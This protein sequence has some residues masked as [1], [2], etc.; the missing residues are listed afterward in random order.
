MK[1]IKI[2]SFAL[3][4]LVTITSC[5]SSKITSAWKAQD[6]TP[7]H[8][9]KILVLGLIREKDRSIQEY[10]ENH[11]VGDLKDLGYD[12]VSSLQ[13]YGP[14]AFDKMEEPEVINSLKSS[15]I[16]AVITIVLLDKK[17]EQKYIPGNIYYTP[18][19]YYSNRFWH[20]R[21]TLY[22][23]IYEPG[24]YMINTKYFWESNLYDMSTQKLIYSVQTQSFD[25]SNL[26]TMGHEYG[27]MIINNMIK[28]D[29]LIM[30]NKEAPP[31]YKD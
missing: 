17:R 8:F 23:R 21:F 20:Y 30:P 9:N 28:N 12:A 5:S 27:K 25:P 18:Y 7:R 4:I 13:V 31:A 10:M 22:N 26:E 19:G 14:K 11:M 6:I 29:V 3:A 2:L 15:G 16:D 24:Y 1:S